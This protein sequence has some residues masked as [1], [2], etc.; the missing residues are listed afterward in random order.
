LKNPLRIRKEKKSSGGAAFHTRGEAQDSRNHPF[1]GTRVKRSGRVG[2]RHI[3]GCEDEIHRPYEIAIRD[4]STGVCGPQLGLVE[5]RWQRSRD[6]AT[7]E[8]AG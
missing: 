3:G 1:G 5:D 8:F 7:R 2:V 4:I 6:L